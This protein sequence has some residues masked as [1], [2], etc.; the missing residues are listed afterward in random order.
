M[1]RDK[2][3]KEYLSL[4]VPLWRRPDIAWSAGRNSTTVLF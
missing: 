1:V 4:Q 2:Q 3:R